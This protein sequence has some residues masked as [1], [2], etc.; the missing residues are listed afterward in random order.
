VVRMI[1]NRPVLCGRGFYR[2]ADIIDFLQ[3][4]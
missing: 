3:K 2:F 1:D 4:G